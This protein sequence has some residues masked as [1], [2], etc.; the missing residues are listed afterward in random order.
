[1][2]WS[3]PWSTIHSLVN[4]C[5][6]ISYWRIMLV[7]HHCLG[8]NHSYFLVYVALQ[9]YPKHYQNPAIATKNGSFRHKTSP[10][11]F[12]GLVRS[13]CCTNFAAFL[14]LLELA[15]IVFVLC[16]TDEPLKKPRI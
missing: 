6:S 16:L 10:G 3:W 12:A 2:R 13:Y 1:A 14:V 9:L 7:L 11:Y 15:Y 4:G 8:G 5:D